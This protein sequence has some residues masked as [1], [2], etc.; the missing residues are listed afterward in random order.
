[1]HLCADSLASPS[2]EDTRPLLTSTYRLG[3]ENPGGIESLSRLA[4]ASP[5]ALTGGL[6]C[7]RRA[8]LDLQPP[9]RFKEAL[10][11]AFESAGLQPVA[12]EPGRRDSPNVCWRDAVPGN[13]HLQ[14]V[15]RENIK[16]WKPASGKC[17]TYACQPPAGQRPDS[18]KCNRLSLGRAELSARSR[19]GQCLHAFAG[20]TAIKLCSGRGSAGN[21]ATSPQTPNNRQH[22]STLM[23]QS[24]QCRRLR[25]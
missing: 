20:S 19:A 16:S 21:T 1:M 12:G 3:I 13:M 15:H 4:P 9:K 5:T 17:S 22:L 11:A 24:A 7:C 6:H 14:L 10:A 23:S 18:C 25:G 8:A 2:G